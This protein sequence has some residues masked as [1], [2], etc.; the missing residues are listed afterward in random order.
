MKAALGSVRNEASFRAV[1]NSTQLICS[2]NQ[3][4]EEKFLHFCGP[5]LREREVFE[6]EILLFKLMQEGGG[7]LFE[8]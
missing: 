4:E 6:G 3:P 8:E 7:F 2:K 5:E 1:S